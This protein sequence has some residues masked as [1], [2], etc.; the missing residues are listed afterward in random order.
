MRRGKYRDGREWSNV[1]GNIYVECGFVDGKLVDTS[2][3]ALP[4][5]VAKELK[6][7]FPTASDNDDTSFTLD[8][9]FR[10]SGYY[11]PGK[12]YGPPE[13]CYPPEGEDERLIDGQVVVSF[14]DAEKTK[15]LSKEASDELFSQFED[16]IQKK[17]LGDWDDEPDYEPDYDYDYDD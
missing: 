11:D 17:E 12:T 4:D 8:I 3:N 6:E 15:K 7:L 9:A 16:E 5:I 2:M 13:N 14:V 10:S 1:P